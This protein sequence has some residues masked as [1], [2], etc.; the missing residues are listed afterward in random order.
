M[1]VKACIVWRITR[2]GGSEE[3]YGYDVSGLLNEAVNADAEVSF[4]RDIMGRII[5]ESSNG[6]VINSAY[7]LQGLR[8]RLTSTLG[9]DIEA[10]YNPFGDLENI[11]TQGWTAGFRH[12]LAG[13]ET[14]RL[15]PGN[16]RLLTTHDSLGRVTGQEIFKN[17]TGIEK[18][19][20]L[21]GLNDRLLSVNDNGKVRQY[22]YDRRGYP[23]RTKYA[24]GTTE[25]RVPD[26]GEKTFRYDA[27]GRRI[28]KRFNRAITQWV[29]DGN[30]PLHE[31]KEIHKLDYEPDR[32]HFTDIQ[33]QQWRYNQG[34][35]RIR[36]SEW[37]ISF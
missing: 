10:A 17:I 20:Y 18:K 23:T 13:L 30:V 12:D 6:H 26:S 37:K 22:E 14:E 15:L 32:G 7:N 3:T 36:Q 8:T 19:E 4:E 34:A 24:D 11:D 31:W 21:W 5:K 9:A 1:T 28:E 35:I 27:L 33:K 25:I 29:W 2:P 16:I